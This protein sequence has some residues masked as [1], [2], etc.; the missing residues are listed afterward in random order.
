MDTTGSTTSPFENFEGEKPKIIGSF[1]EFGSI[2]YITKWGKFKKKMT[3]KTFKAI[4]V[5]YAENNTRDA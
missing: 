3:D 2:V 5:G 1:S 4:M